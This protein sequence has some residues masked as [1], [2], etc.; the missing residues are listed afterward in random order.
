VDL[1]RWQGRHTDQVA[2]AEATLAIMQAI[3][4]LV[5]ELRG[6]RAPA[7]RWDPAE[8]GQPEFG[9]LEE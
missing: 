9:R 1:S 3:T 6:E 2:L 7:E 8:H 5:E 4:V